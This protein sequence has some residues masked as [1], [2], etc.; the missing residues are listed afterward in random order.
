M[1]KQTQGASF[2]HEQ[3]VVQTGVNMQNQ[4]YTDNLAREGVG[5]I[6]AAANSY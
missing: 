4:Q 2:M 3:Y 5:G 6:Y 1:N